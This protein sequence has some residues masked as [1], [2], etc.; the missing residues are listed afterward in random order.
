M[1]TPEKIVDVYLWFVLERNDLPLI[2]GYP[3]INNLNMLILKNKLDQWK[4]EVRLL[5]YH[6]KIKINYARE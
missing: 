3:D 1:V 5:G 2:E 6:P 4:K